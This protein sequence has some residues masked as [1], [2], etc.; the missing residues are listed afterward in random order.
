M[1]PNQELGAEAFSALESGGVLV[2]EVPQSFS[3]ASNERIAEYLT[4][5]LGDGQRETTARM[6]ALGTSDP[7]HEDDGE[8]DLRMNTDEEA[9]FLEFVNDPANQ[10]GGHL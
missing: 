1:L 7:G 6:A 3:E 5:Q 4:S 9:E 8:A 10:L 2:V